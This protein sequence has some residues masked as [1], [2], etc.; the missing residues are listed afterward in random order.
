MKSPPEDPV[1]SRRGQETILLVADE[2][3][4]LKLAA[5]ILK[6]QGYT[7]LAAS[8]PGEA[9]HL[10]E[11][12][13]GEIHLLLTDVIMPE[14]NGRSLARRLLSLYPNLK[15]LFMSGYT[16]DVIANHGV[17]EA[18]VAFVQKPFSAQNLAKS[19]LEALG[20]DKTA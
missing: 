13:P 19:V 20:T 15:C 14:M 12:H 4:M 5:T 1:S 9:I 7:V 11:E 2:P 6:R 16:S 18:G 3:A 10:A 8:A 17:L